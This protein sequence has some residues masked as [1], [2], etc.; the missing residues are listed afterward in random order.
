MKLLYDLPELDQAAF[1]KAVASHND[2]KERL[3]YCIPFNIL[4]DKFVSGFV[5]FTN[6]RMYKIL[7]GTVLNEF[8]I[9]GASDFK[10]E[11]MYGSCGFYAKIDGASTL[12][13]QFISGRNLPRYAVCMP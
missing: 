11:V 6:R 2:P 8:P 3:M 4:D 1:D 7:D 9:I 5:A 12:I 13:C 10:T